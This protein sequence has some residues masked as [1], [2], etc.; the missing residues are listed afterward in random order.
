MPV[1][2]KDAEQGVRCDVCGAYFTTE[3]LRSD[4]QQLHQATTEAERA[5]ILADQNERK[6]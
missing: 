1:D 2:K 3:A 6:P 5:S 4:H